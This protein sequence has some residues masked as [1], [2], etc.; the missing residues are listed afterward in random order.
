MTDE[1]NTTKD[2]AIKIHNIIGQLLGEESI[3]YASAEFIQGV[4]DA[5]LVLFGCID[6]DIY[7]VEYEDDP[8]FTQYMFSK[9]HRVVPHH[10]PFAIET[11]SGFF[12]LLNGI[13]HSTHTN[14][15]FEVRHEDGKMI[16]SLVVPRTPTL[17]NEEHD[18][19]INQGL[20]ECNRCGKWQDASTEMYWQGEQDVETNEI[21]SPHIAVC[22]NCYEA[23]KEL[24]ENSRT[25]TP[26]SL[27]ETIQSTTANSI[28]NVMDY[29]LE[30]EM[31]GEE[32]EEDSWFPIYEA[33]NEL[34]EK[35]LEEE[36]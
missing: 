1:E 20:G 18:A 8:D 26:R 3:T 29:I 17:T 24:K 33:L 19:R 2:T 25:F 16:T 9:T 30:S 4:F 27:A 23:L 14:E 36:E 13:E 28:Q 12:M 6:D 10:F 5:C 11:A 34:K 7:L 32:D 15:V 31:E 22:D 35:A 21:I